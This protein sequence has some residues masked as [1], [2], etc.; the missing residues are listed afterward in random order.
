VSLANFGNKAG[1]YISKNSP[2]I[3]M[4]LSLAGVLTTAWLT[5]KA[6]E[7]ALTDLTVTQMKSGTDLTPKEKV[8]LTWKYYIPPV[9]SCGATLAFII[10]GNSVQSRRQAALITAVSLGETAFSEYK[11]KMVETLGKGKEKKAVD[12]LIQKKVTEKENEGVLQALI[13]RE[14][15]QEQYVFDTFSG[16][17]LV[18]TVEKLNKAANEVARECINNDYANLNLFYSKIGLPEI[19]VGEVVGWNNDNPMEI[20]LGSAVVHE[21]KGLIA[22][23]YVNNPRVGYDS[24]H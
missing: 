11:D 14:D 18:S 19:P 5:H 1:N 23:K 13:P 3:L 21:N 12:E 16:R 2:A 6:A 10:A 20:D 4:G 9:L 24:L 7:K 17:V 15:H 22:I 8:Q